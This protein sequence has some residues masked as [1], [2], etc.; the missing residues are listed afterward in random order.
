M[1]L[2]VLC[3][4]SLVNASKRTFGV[5]SLAGAGCQYFPHRLLPTRNCAKQL[6]RL[7]SKL[8][9]FNRSV[10]ALDGSNWAVEDV[11]NSCAPWYYDCTDMVYGQPKEATWLKRVG[12]KS[13]LALPCS[14]EG[15]VRGVL[16]VAMRA[17][18]VDHR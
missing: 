9:V 12:M 7:P 10:F 18:A 11:T 3:S 13:V 6:R 4:V 8:T 15:V 16:V 2:C 17:K 1:S 14:T 5:A